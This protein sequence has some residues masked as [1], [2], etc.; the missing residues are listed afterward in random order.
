MDLVQLYLAPRLLGAACL[1]W[2]GAGRF[3]IGQLADRSVRWLDDDVL[4]EGHV[5]GSH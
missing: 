4:V 5:H 1:K 3:T 2:L